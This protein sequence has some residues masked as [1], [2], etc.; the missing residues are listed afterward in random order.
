MDFPNRRLRSHTCFIKYII[1][2]IGSIGLNLWGTYLVT[3]FLT[4]QESF[5]AVNQSTAFIIAK[6]SVSVMV[7]V[8]WNYNLHKTFVFKDAHINEKLKIK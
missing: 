4:Q 3:E 8:L 7:A 6:I 2:W 5:I 1:V